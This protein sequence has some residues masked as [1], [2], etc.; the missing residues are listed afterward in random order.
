M[1]LKKAHLLYI[2]FFVLLSVL[3][4]AQPQTVDGVAAIVGGDVILK[5]DIDEQYDVFN[6][7]NFGKP[8]SYCEVFEELLFQKLLIHHAA[9]DSISIGEEEVEANMDRRIQQ[10][11]MQ[12]GDQK[13]LEDFYEKSVVEIKEDMRTLI[14]EQ[15][16][17]QRMQM[18]VVEGI[19]V[20]PSEVRE[21]YENLPADSIPL[22]SAEV[23][24]SQIVKFP[25]LSDEA[26]QEVIAK[27][28]E[29]K[30]R[31]E[32]GTSFSSMA[33]LYSEDPGSNKKGG[34][35]QGIQRGVFVKEFEAV[36]FNLRK[37]EISDPFK[38]EFGYHIVQLLE[39]RGEEL[40]LRHILIKPKLTQENLQEAKNFLDSVSVAIANGEMT[41]EEASRR[42]SDDEQTRFNGG[43]MSNFQSGNNKFEVSQLDRGLF[44][45]ISSLEDD[46]IS[47]AS[48]YRT[49]DQREAFRI[50]R[51]DAN[52]EP[53]KA[54]LDLDFTRIKGFALQ[55]K[56]AKTVEDWK[57]EKLADTFVKIN[58]GYYD[59][60]DELNSWNSNND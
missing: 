58:E 34:E 56:Q 5:S 17:A 30:E 55:Q 11:I 52:Y 37:G 46:E 50:V 6:R 33:I 40:D 7:Q 51:L 31:I 57:N 42:F 60:A 18:T 3:A 48:F 32:N 39:K 21:Y 25:E 12:M 36:A 28:K 38:T 14:K 59:C 44:A 15:L 16:T 2:N 20:T 24:L 47:E 19:E 9:I 27:L 45:L 13:K 53:H 8:V 1:Q 10:L 54:N 23:E 43:Q 22:I 35:Y 4:S 41:F 26:E 29:L 49:E